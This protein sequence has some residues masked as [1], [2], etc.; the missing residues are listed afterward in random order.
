M[1]LGR[2]DNDGRAPDLGGV[3][4]ARTLLEVIDAWE[5]LGL[6]F[7]TAAGLPRGWP[8]AGETRQAG[9]GAL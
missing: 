2:M 3:V 7:A 9:G 6:V 8:E 1:A 5:Y 4:G